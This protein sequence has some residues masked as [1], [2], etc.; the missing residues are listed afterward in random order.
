[1]PV[2]DAEPYPLEFDPKT[3]AVV[4]I[5]M[6]RDFME[7]GGF[8][9]L[10]GNDV[11]PM[12]AAVEPARRVLEAARRAGIFVIHTRE[13]HRPDLSDLPE[14]K[15]L[16]GK[17]DVKIGDMGPMGRVLVRGENGQDIIPEV[18]PI[19]GEPVIDKPGKGAF[20]ATDLHVILANRGIKTL[21]VCGVTLEVCVHTT[22]REANDRGYNSLVV[23]DATASYFPEFCRVGLEMIKAQGA[24]FGWLAE[25]HEVVKRFDEVAV[26]QPA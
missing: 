17:L 18:Y 4:M 24:I 8:G 16:R 9:E 7:P 3:T 25:S 19:K 12:R 23:K 11:S 2:F 13:G 26:A 6:Q 20:W 14:S 15:Y 1:M 22:V 21:V 5:D 10:L